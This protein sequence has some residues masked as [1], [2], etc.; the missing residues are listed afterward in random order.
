M[1]KEEWDHDKFIIIYNKIARDTAGW[2]YEENFSKEQLKEK[3]EQSGDT[4]IQDFTKHLFYYEQ[5]H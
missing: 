5:R 1:K 3:Y 2:L 4:T